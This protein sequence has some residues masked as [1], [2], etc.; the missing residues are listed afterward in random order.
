M[1]LLVFEDGGMPVVI[2]SLI[3]IFVPIIVYAIQ[4][5]RGKIRNI[6]TLGADEVKFDEKFPVIKN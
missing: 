3:V 4:K 1:V 6:V 2:I 5:K